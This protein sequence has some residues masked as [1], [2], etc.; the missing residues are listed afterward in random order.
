[1]VERGEKTKY[2]AYF[3]S[4]TRLQIEYKATFKRFQPTIWGQVIIWQV[5]NMREEGKDKVKLLWPARKRERMC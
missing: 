2:M 5:E 1:M 4:K 3:D